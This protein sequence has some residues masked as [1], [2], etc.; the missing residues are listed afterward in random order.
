MKNFFNKLLKPKIEIPAPEPHPNFTNIPE[1]MEQKVAYFEHKYPED[2]QLLFNPSCKDYL[3]LTITSGTSLNY[4]KE[5]IELYREIKK[6]YP[7]AVALAKKQY[8]T[9][10]YFPDGDKEDY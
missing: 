2:M 7:E 9:Y 4:F 3:P 6:R 5:H 1:W 10:S 8:T